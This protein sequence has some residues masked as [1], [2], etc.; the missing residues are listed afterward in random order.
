MDSLNYQ[1]TLIQE[2]IYYP[3]LYQNQTQG[4]LI[5]LENTHLDI[6]N[7]ENTDF[8]NMKFGNLNWENNKTFALKKKQ[9][10]HFNFVSSHLYFYLTVFFK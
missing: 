6:E 4:L 2:E 8:E 3:N 5:K 9:T 10:K 7:K 1:S